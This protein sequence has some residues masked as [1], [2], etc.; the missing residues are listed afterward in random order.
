LTKATPGYSKLKAVQ[1]GGVYTPPAE[2]S[3]GYAHCVI[4]QSLLDA[5]DAGVSQAILFTGEENY[6]AQKAYIA[7]GFQHVGDYRLL[8]LREAVKVKI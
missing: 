6:A 1:I 5:R 7:L 3:R 8:I 4:A 2:R